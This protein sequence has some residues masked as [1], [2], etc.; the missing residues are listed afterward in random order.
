MTYGFLTI[1]LL[2]ILTALYRLVRRRVGTSN[3][4]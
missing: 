2:V 1:G 3:V 4:R